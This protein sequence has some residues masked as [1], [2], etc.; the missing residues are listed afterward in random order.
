MSFAERRY[1]WV[2]ASLALSAAAACALTSAAAVAQQAK[3]YEAPRVDAAYLAALAKLPD[4]NGTWAIE[5]GIMFD[6]YNAHY[7]ED[8]P[9][10]FG[11][12][13]GTGSYLTKIPLTPEYKAKYDK[14]LAAA[15]EGKAEDPYGSCTQP[16][17]MPRQMGG[18]PGGPE[19]IMLPGQVRITWRHHNA[20]RRI[21]TDGRKNPEGDDLIPTYMGYSVGRWEGDML[22]VETVGMLAG[23]LDQS[24]APVSDQ[25]KTV[26]RMKMVAPDVLYNEITITDPLALTAPWK[27]TRKYTRVSRDVAQ[28]GMY[29]EGTRLDMSGGFQRVVLPGEEEE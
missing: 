19:I 9:L 29:C 7:V 26:E 4:W 28:E 18:T 5:D 8:D 21:Y 13:V 17:G 14:F 27:V 16:H 25:V 15:L 11:R 22:V 1:R 3:A 12:G 23:I 24:G 10:T 2:R 20:T 6:P